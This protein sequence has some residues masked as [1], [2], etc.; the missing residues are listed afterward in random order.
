[1]SVIYNK[2]KQIRKHHNVSQ[3]E[4]ANYLKIKR[5]SL[6][7]IENMHYNP[8]IRIISEIANFFELPIGTI[9]FNYNVSYED[10]KEIV[11]QS[12]KIPNDKEVQANA[13]HNI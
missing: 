13:K 5:T 6:S 7:K 2:I 1:M 8:S 4:L 9:F 11:S 10:T 3:Q 12:R